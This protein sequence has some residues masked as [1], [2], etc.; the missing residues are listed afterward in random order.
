A[1]AWKRE[2]PAGAPHRAEGSSTAALAPAGRGE[3]NGALGRGCQEMPGGVLKREHPPCGGG[4]RWCCS[5]GG[6]SGRGWPAA[7]GGGVTASLP[8]VA[9]PERRAEVGRRVVGFGLG[10]RD[11]DGRDR[12]QEQGE[13]EE[14]DHDKAPW[15]GLWAWVTCP[16]N[17]RGA[18]Q[19]PKKT[20][21]RVV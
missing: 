4:G 18:E 14:C 5:V 6:W 19:G 9:G 21:R 15:V 20:P 12:R 7:G 3:S 1:R 10:A 2:H 8:A 13:G 11:E 17:D 16:P